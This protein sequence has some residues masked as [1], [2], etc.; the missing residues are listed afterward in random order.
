MIRFMENKL[1]TVAKP[2]G[3][4]ALSYSIQNTYEYEY[5]IGIS[6]IVVICTCH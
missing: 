2:K 5:N 3:C 4:D 1:K 6:N